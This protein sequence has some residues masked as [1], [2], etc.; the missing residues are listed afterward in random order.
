MS[1]G[2]SVLLDSV[3]AL[4]GCLRTEPRPASPG[5]VEEA[6]SWVRKVYAGNCRE[7]LEH[8]FPYGLLGRAAP[9]VM[10]PANVAKDWNPANQM[11]PMI[12]A[13]IVTVA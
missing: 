4:L 8:I 3:V 9:A 2:E 10:S 12:S 1:W 13:P 6:G 11:R 7:L 5:A